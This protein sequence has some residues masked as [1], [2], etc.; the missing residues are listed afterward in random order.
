MVRRA[1]V[2]TRRPGCL[3]RASGG[4][5]VLGGAHVVGI[6][7]SPRERGWSLPLPFRAV[8]RKVFPARAGVV[9]THTAVLSDGQRLPRASGG[10]PVLMNSSGL[11]PGSSP[12]ERGWSVHVPLA[13]DIARVFP[14]RAGVVHPQEDHQSYAERL[15]RA[16]GG[17]PPV[18]SFADAAMPS[19]PRERG[20]SGLDLRK[21][22]AGWVFPARAGVVRRAPHMPRT[23]VAVFPARA[24]VVPRLTPR[25]ADLVGLPR[26]SGGG[27]SIP[28]ASA[29]VQWSS[30]RERGWSRSGPV[31]RFG[32][33]VFPA[34]AGVV[35]PR[36]THASPRGSLPRASGGGPFTV[37]APMTVVTSS[38]RERGW[39]VL[40]VLVGRGLEVF[41]ARAGVVP[42]GLTAGL[43][44]A[45]LPRASG[46]GPS[47]S[48]SPTTTA[49]SSPRERGWSHVAALVAVHAAVFPARAGVVR[50]HHPHPDPTGSLP[51]ASGGGPRSHRP[52]RTS[53]R[54][55]PRERGWSRAQY[56]SYAYQRV[57][58]ARAGVVPP[59]APAGSPATGLP[60]ASGGGPVGRELWLHH[61]MSSPRE[62]GWSSSPSCATSPRKS[63]PRERGWSLPA[64]QRLGWRRVFPARAGVVPRTR[65]R[66]SPTPT[67]SP[68]ERGWSC[69][70][71]G[72][73]IWA[74]VFPA[75]AGVVRQ[76]RRPRRQ[77]HGL[78][79][80]SGGG[81]VRRR[82]SGPP[83]YI[84]PAQ[85]GVV[86]QGS[87]TRAASRCL[88]H[89][90]GGGPWAA[91]G[92]SP[93]RCIFPA[94]AE[95]VHP[96]SGAGRV[97]R[98]RCRVSGGG[99]K[100]PTFSVG[101]SAVFSAH[102]SSSETNE[103]TTQDTSGSDLTTHASSRPAPG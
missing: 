19:S 36:R 25:P 44:E 64:V 82:I 34:R 2:P 17:G 49:T 89:A 68:R 88:S 35:R 102:A 21:G 40:Q 91:A 97:R 58:P 56:P 80:A 54:S 48:P 50:R 14:A 32:D 67:S 15:P 8:A 81:P 27:P 76:P 94:R 43:V 18:W 66:G 61:S 52:W 100:L 31:E 63:S 23:L 42:D 4:G 24:G 103:S 10:G 33:D 92:C 3:P 7:S 95:V 38:P 57:F 78:L 45:C 79:R 87:S 12:R 75:R 84:F 5:P 29:S 6:E 46:G 74:A 85:V 30:P 72:G 26:A 20:W 9:L 41:P 53:L 16:S 69:R 83:P 90:G 51:R 59:P 71:G 86:R 99:S 37:V 60:C 28:S 96:E 47:V 93:V 73:S 13:G 55:S 65:S 62:R 98:G 101:D 39:S 77:D 70:G 22:P 1:R 11:M